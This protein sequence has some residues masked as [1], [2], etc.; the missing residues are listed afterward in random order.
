MVVKDFDDLVGNV[1]SISLIKKGLL[2]K[3]L[4]NM[5]FLKG[6]HGIG[7]SSI[8]TLIGKA[9]TCI[10]PVEGLACGGCEVCKKNDLALPVSGS[11]SNLV[12]VNM[13]IVS[14]EGTVMEQIR[15]IFMLAKPSGHYVK[16]L[17]EFHTLK[18]SEQKLFL[19]ET[20]RLSPN[21]TLILTST[22]ERSVIKEIRSRCLSFDFGPLTAGESA[23]LVDRV[24]EGLVF[25]AK[26][27]TAIFRRTRGIPRDIVLLVEFL[28]KTRPT[29]EELDSFLGVVSVSEFVN[30]FSMMG[31]FR[32]YRETYLELL[33]S[34]E[35]DMFYW[36]FRDFINHLTFAI[37]GEVFEEISCKDLQ[38][39][40]EIRV[41]DLYKIQKL[42]DSVEIN[43]TSLELLFLRIR[44]MFVAEQTV[45]EQKAV[46]R[47]SGIG[48]E[49]QE[50]EVSLPKF[51]G[52]R[53]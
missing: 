17:E 42:A 47:Q 53:K 28:S 43:S 20:E 19:E 33:K 25:A 40:P 14:K 5:L 35:L 30:I 44:R 22:S 4:P 23:L 41:D 7:K 8:A 1:L 32:L 31:D 9:L 10:S 24:R 36:Q 6:T 45:S 37:E 48:K 2:R 21:V 3:S 38:S 12:K 13:A 29:R 52:S 50:I 26:D 27:Y 34:S 39:L 15:D 11:S 51:T 18:E 49:I 46:A 16:I